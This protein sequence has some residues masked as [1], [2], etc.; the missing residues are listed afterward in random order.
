[1]N[2][3]KNNDLR[4]KSWT[5]PALPINFDYSKD[6]P[7]SSENIFQRVI[8]KDILSVSEVDCFICEQNLLLSCERE[9]CVPNCDKSNLKH[10]I[11]HVANV[12][13]YFLPLVAHRDNFL[14]KIKEFLIET[15]QFQFDECEHVNSLKER[16]INKHVTQLSKVYF[17]FLKKIEKGVQPSSD[18][19]CDQLMQRVYDASRVYKKNK[20]PIRRPECDD[21][22]NVLVK[23]IRTYQRIK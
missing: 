6:F 2:Y 14:T 19:E 15:V 13:L 5:L 8:T 23:K 1:M 10:S 12:T 17:E 7:D 4:E 3:N 16:V 21:M 18:F 9:D 20:V 11:L 22:C